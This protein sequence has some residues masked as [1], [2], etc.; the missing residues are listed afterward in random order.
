[1]NTQTSET[2]RMTDIRQF[3]RD[4]WRLAKPYWSSEDRWAARALLGV[5]VAM[6]LGLVGINVLVN[7][8]PAVFFHQLW[9]FTGLAAAFIAVAVYQLYLNQ[10]LQI[11]WRRWLTDRYLNAWLSDR[12]Y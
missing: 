2:H 3:L 12:T 11:R 9:V 10:M 4:T 1:M 6:N 7:R 8:W 5:V